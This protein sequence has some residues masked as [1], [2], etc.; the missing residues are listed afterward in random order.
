VDKSVDRNGLIGSQRSVDRPVR[1]LFC[2]VI[3][4]WWDC[5]CEWGEGIRSGKLARPRTVVRGGVPVIELRIPVIV[6]SRS[7]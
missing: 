1:C 4:V 7:G 2:G 3:G 6:I 5:G